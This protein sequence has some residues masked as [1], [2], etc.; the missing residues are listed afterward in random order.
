LKKY[1]IINFKTYKESFDKKGENLIKEILKCQDLAK[2]KNVEIIISPNILD[3]KDYSKKFKIPFFSQTSSTKLHGA[4]TGN[5]ILEFLKNLKINGTIINHSEN[6]I[7]L[8]QIEEIVKLS[9]INK[10]KVCVCS[11]NF[12]QIKKI[13]K[14]NPDF[15]AYEPSELIGTNKSV[16]TENP[17]IIQKITKYC[18]SKILVGAGIKNKID[19]EKSI[20]YKS[21]G[22]LIASGIVKSKNVKKD[23]TDLLNGF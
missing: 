14:L 20:E 3:L 13:D 17:K 21:C 6:Q 16:T 9:K 11:N 1:L 2:K 18:K 7:S 5:I 19:V 23:L 12:S 4:N 8:K 15:I 22:I 10:F